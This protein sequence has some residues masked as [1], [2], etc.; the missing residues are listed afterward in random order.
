MTLAT[1]PPVQALVIRKADRTTGPLVFRT[2]GESVPMALSADAL[3]QPESHMPDP[4]IDMEACLLAAHEQGRRE[5]MASAQT[6]MQQVI[7]V[8]RRSVSRFVQQFEEEKQRY[9]SDVEGEVVKLSL[10]IAERVLR[11]ESEMDPT[12]LAGAARVALEQVAD[13]SG[14][15]LRVPPDEVDRWCETFGPTPVGMVIEG[16]VE[17]LEGECVLKTRSGSVQLGMR[18]QLG[19]IERGFFDVLG[20]AGHPPRSPPAEAACHAA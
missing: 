14:T 5:A 3:D 10:A 17:M 8:E 12:L 4:P 11:R 1:D 15:V 16:D 6:E 9:F 20:R 19:E 2:L 7:Q 18:A 13:S